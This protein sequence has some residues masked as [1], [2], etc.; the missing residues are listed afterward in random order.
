MRPA[1]GFSLIEVMVACIIMLIGVMGFVR[2]QSHI[3]QSEQSRHIAGIARQLAHEKLTDLRDFKTLHRMD[4]NSSFQ[5]IADNLG[6]KIVAGDIDISVDGDETELQRFNQQWQVRDQFYVDTDN[7]NVKD[8][9]RDYEDIPNNHALP[10]LPEQKW[11]TIS[12]KWTSA[13]GLTQTTSLQGI[14]SPVLSYRSIH[15]IQQTPSNQRVPRVLLAESAP[16]MKG[17]HLINGDVNVSFSQPSWPSDS[18]STD[19]SITQFKRHESETEVLTQA[20][21]RTINCDCQIAGAGRGKTPSMT[22]LKDQSLVNQPGSW[23]NKTVGIATAGQNPLCSSCCRD[24]HDTQTMLVEHSNY[25]PGP[26]AHQHF[27]INSN[28]DYTLALN[29]A[30]PYLEICRFKRI[31]GQFEIYP[32]WQLINLTQFDSQY[33]HDESNRLAYQQHVLSSLRAALNNQQPASLPLP[34]INMFSGALQLLSRGIYI[35]KLRPEHIEFIRQKVASRQLDWLDYL[36][37][38]DIDVTLLANWRSSAEHIATISQQ[39]YV[40][41]VDQQHLQFGQYSRGRVSGL[42]IGQA[43][44]AATIHRGNA[45]LSHRPPHVPPSNLHVSQANTLL[46][47]VQGSAKPR[48]NLAISGDVA[49]IVKQ[50]TDYVPCQY[51]D[52]KRADYVDLTSLRVS[53]S[54]QEFTCDITINSSPNS[55]FFNCAPIT[56]KWQGAL[57]LATEPVNPQISLHWVSEALGIVPGPSITLPEPLTETSNFEYQVLIIVK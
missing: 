47:S 54:A 37:F 2:L 43:Q 28:G 27:G 17:S 34:Q 41:E 40:L 49:C 25:S 3:M 46:L 42:T 8:S 29:I 10:S 20:N 35:E 33:L 16:A 23:V 13:K 15:G 1:Y 24:H 48:S 30:D 52:P 14:V 4:E 57:H 5:S 22:I 55:S 6:G 7:D 9:W 56:E 12:V 50:V 51:Q 44:I 19:I 21:F 36:P 11:V 38:Y 31:D 45:G 18:A 39:P 32:D 26:S 53:D